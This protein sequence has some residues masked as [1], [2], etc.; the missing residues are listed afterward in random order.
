MSSLRDGSETCRQFEPKG[1]LF[2]WPIAS[3][4]IMNQKVNELNYSDNLPI[5]DAQARPRPR[6]GDQGRENGGFLTL[7]TRGD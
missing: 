7:I 2:V 1:L 5:R 3:T 6:Q 4:F